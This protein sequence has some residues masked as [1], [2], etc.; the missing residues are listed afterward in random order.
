M[1]TVT[2]WKTS[3]FHRA[4]GLCWSVFKQEVEVAAYQ[5]TLS[6]EKAGQSPTSIAT[7]KLPLAIH[8]SGLGLGLGLGLGFGVRV[9][10]FTLPYH[11]TVAAF[12]FWGGKKI[13]PR[14]HTVRVS[15]RN[16]K[17]I[18]RLCYVCQNSVKKN[19]ITGS[20]PECIKNLNHIFSNDRT[21]K[22]G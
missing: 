20:E 10:S 22:D 8:Q 1:T 12:D 13:R 4:E 5:G 11:T 19:L 14:L 6:G 16:V 15:L 9:H 18:S 2:T 3:Y 17:I 7:V 21:M